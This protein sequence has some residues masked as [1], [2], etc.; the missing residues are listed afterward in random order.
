[1]D[2]LPRYYFRIREN[3]AA[4]YLLQTE[5]RDRRLEMTEIAAVNIRN[6]AVK[7][8]GSYELTPR[9][10]AEIDRW[11]AAR[12]DVLARRSREQIDGVVEALN[13][14]AHWAQTKATPDELDIV[15]EPLL[16]A[17]HDLRRVLIRKKSARAALADAPAP[18]DAPEPQAETGAA[19]A[20]RSKG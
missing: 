16:L 2:A 18:D 14:A 11:M 5:T 10:S 13:L 12:R 8:H 17:M 19:G 1:M 4:V 3:G 20:P 15:T 9:D 7:P 6:G